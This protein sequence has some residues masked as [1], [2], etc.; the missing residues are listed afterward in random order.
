M[1]LAQNASLRNGFQYNLNPKGINEETSSVRTNTIWIEQKEK[2]TATSAFFQSNDGQ[3]KAVFSKQDI[4]YRDNN[5]AWIPINAGLKIKNE[6]TWSAEQQPFP[7]YFHKNGGAALTLEKNKLIWIGD[8]TRLNDEKQFPVYVVKDNLITGDLKNSVIKTIEFSENKFKYSY[9]LNKPLQTEGSMFHF[10]EQIRLPKGCTMRILPSENNVYSDARIEIINEKGIRVAQLGEPLCYDSKNNWMI[11][12]YEIIHEQNAYF[13]RVSVPSDWINSPERSYPVII[14]PLVVG[15]TSKWTSGTMPSCLHPQ[16]NKDSIQV[17]I[18]AGVTVT[19]LY[20]TSNFYAPAPAT[21]G[22]GI[23]KFGTSCD[24]TIEFTIDPSN[25]QSSLPGTAYLDSANL[26]NPLMCCIPPSC[27]DTNFFLSMY[28]ARKGQGSGC[29]STSIRYD[30]IISND[31]LTSKYAFRAVVIGKTV[32][33]YSAKWD[34]PGTP[35]CSNQCTIT[36]LTSATFGVPPYTFT[37]PWTKDVVTKGTTTG[38]GSNYVN[39]QFTLT[40]PNCPTYCDPNNTSLVV[41]APVITDACGNVINDIPTVT[42]PVKMAPKVTAN[43]NPLICSGVAYSY[44]LTSC[45]GGSVISWEGNNNK[46]SDVITDVAYSDGSGKDTVKYKTWAISNGCYSDTLAISLYFPPFQTDYSLSPQPMIAGKPSEFKGS[47]NDLAGNITEW[48]WYQ[49]QQLTSS[50]QA[51]QLTI[52][53]AGNYVICLEVKGTN[54][55]SD[56]VC[57]TIQVIPAKIFAPNI[58]TPNGDQINDLLAFKFLE[59]YPEN[60]LV[61]LNRWGITVYEADSYKN[62]WNGDNLVE[63]TYFYKLTIPATEQELSGF[64]QIER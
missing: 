19:G 6:T 22:Q 64:F 13:I 5:G 14:D 35:I 23:M 10:D 55:C 29:N 1:C 20:V 12:K 41:P 2:R 36:G 42:L 18:P 60:H 31:P 51:P 34:I 56:S 21:K 62:T 16:F 50:G 44:P 37:H 9:E 40:I 46:G 52:D 7:T 4:H 48:K 15:V 32:E 49:D 27:K 3:F 28:L 39:Q 33:N 11:A 61:V 45:A 8:Q 30:P 47:T 26:L 17:T 53:E 63:G 54:G 58:I 38:C 43:Y 24:V 57:K 59:Y 25:P